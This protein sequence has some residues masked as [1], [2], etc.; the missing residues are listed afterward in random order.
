MTATPDEFTE[1]I[2]QQISE[3]KLIIEEAGI[4]PN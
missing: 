4:L 1:M 2:K 3:Y